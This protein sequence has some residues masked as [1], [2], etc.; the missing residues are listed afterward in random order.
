MAKGWDE[1]NSSKFIRVLFENKH[2]FEVATGMGVGSPLILKFL[3]GS[4]KAWES[5]WPGCR[6]DASRHRGGDRGAVTE[7]GG[8]AVNQSNT[9][10]RQGPL[11]PQVFPAGINKRKAYQARTI[12]DHPEVVAVSFFRL[13]GSIQG[14]MTN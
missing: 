9:K 8:S 2:A 10:G 6:G 7:C 11:G 14:S 5:G 3:G 13:P 1:I 12:K 4:W